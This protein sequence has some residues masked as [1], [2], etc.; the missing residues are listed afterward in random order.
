MI[1]DAELLRRYAADRSEAAFAELVQRHLALV[2]AVA[3]RQVEPDRHLAEDVAQ[4]VF[5][6]LARKAGALSRHPVLTGWLYRST[7]FTAIDLVRSERRRRARE[8][9]AQTMQEIMND[10]ETQPEAEKL[11]PVLDQAMGELGERDRD[12]VMLRFYEGRPFAEVGRKLQLTDDAAR[13][14]VERALDKLRTLLEQR[15]VTSTTAALTATLASQAAGA[16]PVGLAAAVTGGVLTTAGAGAGA[17]VA[18]FMTITKVQ[19]AIFSTLLVAGAGGFVLQQREN[20]RLER[21]IGTGHARPEDIARLQEENQSLAATV[22]EV[23]GYRDDTAELGR[24]RDRAGQLSQ[25]FQAAA[26]SRNSGGSGGTIYPVAQ[27]QQ[28]PTPVVQTAPVYPSALRAAGIGGTVVIAYT[29]GQDGAVI[30][31]RVAKSAP[32]PEFDEA[33]LA[34]VKKWKFTP[35]QK[36][37]AAVNTEAQVPIVFSLS[38]KSSPAWF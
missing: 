24:L 8:Q 1:E 17:V 27:L 4:K 31:A 7:Q 30:D 32:Q 34:A 16:P 38:K 13:R 25:Q 28:A 3:R 2:Y 14:R 18:T 23:R 22:A 20:A 36:D 11:R 15:G 33:A 37:G 21:E 19:V 26:A 9:E 12:A 5:A 6:D 10:S 35:G 29:V